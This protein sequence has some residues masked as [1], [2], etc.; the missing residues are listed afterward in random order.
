MD[1]DPRNLKK[2]LQSGADLKRNSRSPAGSKP[3]SR[4]PQRGS[5]PMRPAPRPG[6]PA[7][8]NQSTNKSPTKYGTLER[9]P[10]QEF[11]LNEETEA[12]ILDVV[13]K[14]ISLANEHAEE[15]KLP[16]NIISDAFLY[17]AA[18]YNAF[19]VATAEKA[20]DTKLDKAEYMK[21]F[22]DQYKA[23]LEEH[24][25]FYKDNPM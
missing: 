16:I 12:Q 9:A 4:P 23:M 25:D 11:E 20:N 15:R 14:F 6:L 13:N 22:R 21:A 3:M 17:A 7:N 5:T 10:E 2:P 18:R 1:K 8:K 24:F 19:L